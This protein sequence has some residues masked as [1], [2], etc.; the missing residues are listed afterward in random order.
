MDTAGSPTSASMDCSRKL[1]GTQPTVLNASE[2]PTPV[3]PVLVM[4]SLSASILEVLL[5]ATVTLPVVPLACVSLAATA[6]FA[7]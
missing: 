4:L 2:M 5:A 1:V 7:M 3:S 6:L